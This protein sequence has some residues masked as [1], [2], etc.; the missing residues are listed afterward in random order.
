MAPAWVGACWGLADSKGRLRRLSWVGA[1]SGVFLSLLVVA[2]ALFSIWSL[3]KDPVDRLRMGPLL[4]EKIADWGAE[5]VVCERYQEAAWVAFYTGIETTTLPNFSRDDQFDL[6]DRPPLG[7]GLY[8]R[9]ASGRALEAEDHWGRIWD[10]T[11]FQVS[12][13]GRKIGAWQVYR[14]AEAR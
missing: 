5:A 9:V 11:R 2:H 3:P 6:W 7:E 10:D 12:H 13:H 14:T 1:F 4:G 8:L